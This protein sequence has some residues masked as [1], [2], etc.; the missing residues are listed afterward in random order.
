MT[1]SRETYD[2]KANQKQLI[3][4]IKFNEK[5]KARIK[6]IFAHSG[7]GKNIIR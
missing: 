7:N 6:Q 4:N 2:S 3:R 5:Y 1:N